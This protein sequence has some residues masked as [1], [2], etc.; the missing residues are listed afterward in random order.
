MFTQKK[1]E[2]KEDKFLNFGDIVFGSCTERQHHYFLN[3]VE[4]W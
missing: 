2:K 4:D 1:D 3:H